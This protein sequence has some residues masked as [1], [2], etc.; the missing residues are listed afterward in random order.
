MTRRGFTVFEITI[1]V[2]L[3]TILFAAIYAVFKAADVSWQEDMGRVALQQESRQAM[4]LMVR[5]LREASNIQIT[6][7]N[8]DAD[9]I[10]FDTTAR[11]GIQYYRDLN[12]NQLI[13]EFPLGTFRV[14]ANHI[15][16]LRFSYPS[17][18]ITIEL[19]ATANVRGRIV[20]F[21]QG[22]VLI[23]RVR[24]RNG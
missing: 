4:D 16:H 9:I 21:P 15:N 19:Q 2:A 5:E 3:V 1:S 6:P 18:V 22:G 13:R 23:E 11:T 24:V 8:P 12:S 14:L 7:V 10:S 17:R 20:S